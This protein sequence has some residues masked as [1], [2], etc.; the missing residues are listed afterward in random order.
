LVLGFWV[1][2]L[3][4]FTFRQKLRDYCCKVIS[5]GFFLQNKVSLPNGEAAM[6]NIKRNFSWGFIIL[7]LSSVWA[8]ELDCPP[9]SAYHIDMRTMLPDGTPN[10]N[11]G[12]LIATGLCVCLGFK[13][14]VDVT[15]STVTLTVRMVDNE[16]VRGI[17]VDIYHNAPGILVYNDYGS[18]TKGEKLE[19][20]TDENGVPRTMT[21]LANEIGDHVKVMAYSTSRARTVGD[22]QEGDLF[23]LT[24]GVPGGYGTLP[25]S[26]AFS[27]GL[28]NIPGTSMEPELL[29]V[30]CTYPDTANPIALEVPS[31][32]VET[33]T[34]IP[35][36]YRLSQN[37][38]NPFNPTTK[39]AF[40]LP[41][42][43]PVHLTI[44]NLLGQRVVTL[45]DKHLEPARYQVEWD[46]TD[47]RGTPVA[48]GIYFYELRAGAFQARKKMLL[49]R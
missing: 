44:Y 41:T 25:D 21:L 40:D 42:A 15:D 38:P 23:Y 35:T 26:I 19:N 6:K 7:F 28:C 48:S 29:N 14:N 12:Q 45:V 2:G 17:E 1:L 20:V 31:L 30:A 11:Y 24:Y 33:F 34:G 22:G 9:D 4:D 36:E 13:A 49:L 10:P 3:F 47:M 43:G 32:G 39:I 16:P 37:Y 8:Q 5:T 18:V 46:G 27:I